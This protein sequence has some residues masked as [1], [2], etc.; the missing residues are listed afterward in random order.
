[1]QKVFPSAAAARF[2]GVDFSGCFGC[3]WPGDETVAAGHGDAVNAGKVPVVIAGLG[4]ID[5][6]GCDWL[7]LE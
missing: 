7:W 4:G 3:D 2:F 5:G 1:M 6:W